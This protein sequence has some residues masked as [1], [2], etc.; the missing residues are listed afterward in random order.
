M[1]TK[2]SYS[3]EELFEDIPGDDEHIAFIVP[4]E[5]LDEVA[6]SSFK[7]K[8]EKGIVVIQIT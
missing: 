5:I 1:T 3:Y 4:A 6:D 2:Y 7:V 8:V